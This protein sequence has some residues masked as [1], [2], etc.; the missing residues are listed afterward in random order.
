MVGHGHCYTI[1]VILVVFKKVNLPL[2]VILVKLGVLISRTI[3]HPDSITIESPSLGR[4]VFLLVQLLALLQYVI[5][6]RGTT[7]TTGLHPPIH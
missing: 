6:P 1:I 7:L 3:F 2:I 4:V 5:L